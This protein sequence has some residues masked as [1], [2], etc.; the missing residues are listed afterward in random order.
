MRDAKTKLESEDEIQSVVSDWLRY[1]FKNF[2][3]EEIQKLVLRLVECVILMED[4]V[5]KKKKIKLL[6]E[7]QVFV[8]N[9]SSYLLN[10]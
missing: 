6:S 7:L 1:Q 9:N 4:Y 3:A 2:Y 8:L 10:L 5:E